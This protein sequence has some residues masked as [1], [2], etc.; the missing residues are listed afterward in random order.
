MVGYHG[1][2]SRSRSQRQSGENCSA[3]QTAAEGT[4][5]MPDRR[6]GG[7]HQIETL[8]HGRRIHERAGSVIQAAGKIQHRKIDRADLLR[9]RSFLQAEQA[10][11]RQG[12]QWRKS[13]KGI[14]RQGS[15]P[16]SRVPC[17]AMPILKPSIAA[18]SAR[19]LSARSGSAHR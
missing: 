19:H 13:A 14:E 15:K 7:H 1:E 12:S 9:A 4:G 17:Q 2:S 6:V 3:S 5:Q 10:Y 8:D 16:K 18:S 11:A